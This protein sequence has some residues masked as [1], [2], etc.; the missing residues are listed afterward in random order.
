MATRGVKWCPTSTAVVG[1]PRAS[2]ATLAL[3]LDCLGVRSAILT[4]FTF[5]SARG[6]EQSSESQACSQQLWAGPL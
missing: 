1:P 2:S 3:V 4:P 6:R 5:L